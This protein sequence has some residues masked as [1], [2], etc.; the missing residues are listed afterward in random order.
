M[1]EPKSSSPMPSAWAVSQL[2]EATMPTTTTATGKSVPAGFVIIDEGTCIFLV[3]NY[4]ST[5][6]S[7]LHVV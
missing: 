6:L 2:L 7:V 4:H 1:Q 3:S 5:C